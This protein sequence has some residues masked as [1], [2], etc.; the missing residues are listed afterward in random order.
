MSK[1]RRIALVTGASRGIGLAIATKLSE[2]YYVIGTSTNSDG[3]DVISAKLGAQGEGFVLRVDDDGSVDELFDNL[4]SLDF[5]PSI[6]VNNAGITSDNL[7][8]RMKR[9]EWDS[10]INTNING[11]Y[12]VVRRSLRAMVRSRWGRIISVSSV[13]A[14]SGNLGQVN[15]AAS[16]AAIEGFSRSLAIEVA[17]RGIT[18]NVVAPGFIDTDMTGRLEDSQRQALIANI[19]IGKIGTAQDIAEAVGFLASEESEY[20]TGE[21]L[22]IN[23]GLYMS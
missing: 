21:T 16:K 18:V 20:I 7:L 15:Y 23:G 9:E 19:P 14:S 22:H 6:V 10:V 8:M 2:N 12:R 17:S 13:V 4:G 1:D 11:I 5:S 3:S